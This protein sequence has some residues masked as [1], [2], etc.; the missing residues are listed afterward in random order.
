MQ[1]LETRLAKLEAVQQASR[2][3]YTDTELAVRLADLLDQGE[4]KAGPEI[5]A[6]LTELGLTRFAK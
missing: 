3:T 1:N 4:A 5:W 2:R 6:K